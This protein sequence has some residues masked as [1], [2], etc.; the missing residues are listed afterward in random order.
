MHKS[1]LT[2]RRVE[3]SAV[4]TEPVGLALRHLSEPAHF[5]LRRANAVRLFYEWERMLPIITARSY[6]E[7]VLV[8]TG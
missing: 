6:T 5:E 2:R 3:D 4:G 8:D 1:K 7:W